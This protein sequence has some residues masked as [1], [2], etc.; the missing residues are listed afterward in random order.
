MIRSQTKHRAPTR[1]KA[2]L[3]VRRPLK[4][5]EKSVGKEIIESLTEAVEILEAGGRLEGR[6]DRFTVRTVE[7]PDDPNEYDAM[8]VKA[9]RKRLGASQ[10]VFARLVGVSIKLVQ[11]W[12]ISGREP[13]LTARRLMDEFNR[14]PRRWASVLSST[15]AETK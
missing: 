1:D 4:R 12:E 6:P 14:E 2:R 8:A 13:S 9:T 7:M 5:V 3:P 11:A 10:A 15:L